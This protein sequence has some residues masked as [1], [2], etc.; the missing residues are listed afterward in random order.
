M[1]LF[2]FFGV[3]FGFTAANPQSVFL[4]KLNFPHQSIENPPI[5]YQFRVIDKHIHAHTHTHTHLKNT[6][7]SLIFYHAITEFGNFCALD[8]Y[9]TTQS[10]TYFGIIINGCC[11]KCAVVVVVAGD[12]DSGSDT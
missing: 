12:G 11:G 8:M 9:S 5:Q 6:Q 4:R 1:R 2:V 10:I 7:F 3:D